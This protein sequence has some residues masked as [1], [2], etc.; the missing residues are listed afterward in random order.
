MEETSTYIKWPRR[1]KIG[2]KTRKDPHVE[3]I[4]KYENVKRAKEQ[5]IGLLNSRV[6]Y[7]LRFHRYFT[8]LPL[9]LPSQGNRVTMKL[10][11]S[12]RD[13]SFIIGK[14][15]KSIKQIMDDT[16][17]HIHFPDSNRFNKHEKSNQVSFTGPLDGVEMA[18]ARVRMSSPL[19][20]QFELPVIANEQKIPEVDSPF[21][22]DIC[23]MYDV[24]VS[25]SH[26]SKLHATSVLVKGSESNGA[27]VRVATQRLIAHLCQGVSCPI[28]VNIQMDVS[29]QYH[30]IVKGKENRNLKRIME[31]SKTKIIFPDLNDTNFSPLRR[32]QISITGT[33]DGVC[34]ARDYIIGNLP[35]ALMFEYPD[36]NIDLDEIA[37]LNKTLDVFITVRSK[38]HHGAL[39]IVIK[40]IE[41]YVGDIYEA[42]S[43]ILKL[44]HPPVTAEIPSSYYFQYENK[45]QLHIQSLFQMYSNSPTALDF[46]HEAQFPYT[47]SENLAHL[48]NR[49]SCMSLSPQQ[50]QHQQGQ[51]QQYQ[52]N[53]HNNNGSMKGM[54]PNYQHLLPPRIRVSTSPQQQQQQQHDYNDGSSYPPSGGAPSTNVS[55]RGMASQNTSGYHSVSSSTNSLDHLASFPAVCLTPI[56]SG[57]LLKTSQEQQQEFLR[58]QGRFHSIGTSPLLMNRTPEQVFPFL[59]PHQQM[60]MQQHQL[61]PGFEIKR[62]FDHSPIF[63]FDLKKLEGLKAMEVPPRPDQ[64]RTPTSV[65]AGVGLSRSS[66]MIPKTSS[67]LAGGSD[68]Q[69]PPPGISPYNLGK[70]GGILDS[71]PVTH[72]Q[73]LMRHENIQSLLT[74]LRLEHYICESFNLYL[75]TF[76]YFKIPFFSFNFQQISSPTKS[77]SICF[78]R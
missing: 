2:A 75:R 6:S 27:N 21:I 69:N 34:E 24:Q 68:Y 1:L 53:N 45:N 58:R 39:C 60:G 16:K 11:V 42:R 3:I 14:C 51:Q 55:P 40:G 28:E 37:Q 38:S 64:P 7:S 63:D 56:P 78:R 30:F 74:S 46:P 9:H 47:P 59:Q 13:H 49:M 70:T 77:I 19:V 66:T 48:M 25:Y 5:V 71:T 10:N 15:G 12:Y 17:T 65:W 44:N 26:R 35:V 23:S 72:R 36:K 8:H 41:K 50:Q 57:S 43:K 54:Q 61:S 20:L 76:F 18:R 31:L 73:Y 22:K 4:G 62:N 52:N 33:I 29:P 67:P 32:C